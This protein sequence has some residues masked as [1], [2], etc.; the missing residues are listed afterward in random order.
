M[1]SHDWGASRHFFESVRQKKK[2]SWYRPK[3]YEH[4]TPRLR[5]DDYRFALSYS[6]SEVDVAKHAFLPLVHTTIKE[7]R[8]KVV[9]AVTGK[10]AH[11]IMEGGRSK[12]TA[13]KR[14]IYYATHLDAQ[15]YSYYS[16][17]VIGP[18]YENLLR[19]TEGL[20]ECVVAYRRL[21]LP[22]GA[23]KSNIHF[24]HEVFEHI[25]GTDECVAMAFDISKFFDS[26]D[27]KLLKRM[28]CKVIGESTLPKDHFNLFKSLT[29]FSFIEMRDVM[30]VKGITHAKEL[31]RRKSSSFCASLSDFR[32]E[33]VDTGLIQKNPFR[34]ADGKAQG[35]PQGTPISAML[36]NLYLYEFDKKVLDMVKGSSVGL[37]RRYSDD[38]VVVCSQGE[39]KTIE[40][41]IVSEIDE[42]CKL[43]IHPKKSKRHLFKRNT[44]EDGR[45]IVSEILDDGSKVTGSPLQYLGFEFDGNRALLKS[46][47]LA[48]YYRKMKRG[49]RIRAWR[50]LVGKEKQKKAPGTDA[51][52]WKK[53][54]YL[55]Y[56]H[57][58]RN[59]KRGNYLTYAFR[60]AEIMN[61]PAIRHQVSRSW[62]I[63][64]AHIKKYEAKYKLPR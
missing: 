5:R 21:A 48:K 38:L 25:K 10:R 22:S 24:A 12:S 18:K 28:W 57:L 30:S 52:L 56:S 45:M 20:S 27:H 4:F 35:I 36:A 49:V 39:A 16:N 63:L 19:G 41:Q 58:G 59:R 6:S 31:R 9:D 14:Q 1:D 3:G 47:S 37:Y 54:V 60:A 50:A 13:K 61:E 42:I 53:K 46:S 8:F 29:R 44:A 34:N 51:K 23:N 55:G 43:L 40:R 17:K 64:Q 15:I 2:K 26:L 62:D 32:K 33:F 7:R 11:R